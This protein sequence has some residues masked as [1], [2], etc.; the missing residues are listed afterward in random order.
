MKTIIAVITAIYF[1]IAIQDT[2]AGIAGVIT[3]LQGECEKPDEK[4]VQACSD[5]KTGELYYIY[6]GDRYK[7]YPIK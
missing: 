1:L 3:Y 6:K 7:E 5:R 4:G 2:H